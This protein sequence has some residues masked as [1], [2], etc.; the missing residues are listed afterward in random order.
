MNNKLLINV[1]VPLMEQDYDLFI[2]IN[3]KVGVVKN[4]IINSIIELTHGIYKPNDKL[5]LYI[6]N[7]GKSLDENVYV[8]EANIS[9]GEKLILY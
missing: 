2:P 6:K 3:K 8:K 1:Y 7:S 9:N 5:K 4:L